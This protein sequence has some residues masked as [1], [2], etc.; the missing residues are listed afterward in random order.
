M[1]VSKEDTF[2]CV[3]RLSSEK[4]KKPVILDFASGTNPGGGWRSA[5]H[6]GSQEE[7][8]CKRSDL[9]LLLEKK[10]YPI[11][12]DSHHYIKTVNINESS[13]GPILQKIQCAVI[14]SELRSI[15][16]RTENYLIKRIVDIYECAISNKHDVIVLGA[17]GCGAFK[18]TNDDSE[19][20]AKIFKKVKNNYDTKIKTVYAVMYT[21]NYE[22]FKRIIDS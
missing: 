12:T 8:L 16:E 6:Q 18:E 11:P 21:K 20:M 2:D 17:W 7:S 13:K 22:T 5:K 14:A 4:Y 9:G 15:C 3:I 10:H 19:I 1:S